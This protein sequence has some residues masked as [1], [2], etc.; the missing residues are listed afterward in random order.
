MQSRKSYNNAISLGRQKALFVP[1]YTLYLRRVAKLW[2][3]EQVLSLQTDTKNIIWSNTVR[4]S[5]LVLTIVFSFPAQAE[6]CLG[7]KW[8]LTERDGHYATYRGKIT[9][10]SA[11]VVH[12]E[13]RNNKGIIAQDFGYPNP[14]GSWEINLYADRK[15][16]RSHKESFVCESY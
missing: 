13:L 3:T 7:L 6:K 16:K 15:V 8:K 11:D 5:F 14:L 2:D 12:I 10:G 1:H 4:V 9:P